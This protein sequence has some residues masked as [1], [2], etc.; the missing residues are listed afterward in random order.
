METKL[1]EPPQLPQQESPAPAPVIEKPVEPTEPAEP[2]GDQPD[3]DDVRMPK[4]QHFV[5]E[6]F[7]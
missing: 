1:E 2:K 3:S 4:F 6:N 5:S 7:A